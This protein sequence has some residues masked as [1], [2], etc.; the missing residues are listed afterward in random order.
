MTKSANPANPLLAD[1]PTAC[2]MLSLGRTKIFDLMR[3][4]NGALQR[5]KIGR[6]TLITMS[7]IRALAGLGDA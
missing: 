4:E 1:V 3:P 6:K 5:V 2:A 7:S